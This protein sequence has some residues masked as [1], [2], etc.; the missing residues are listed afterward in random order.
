M[1]AYMGDS[2][3]SIDLTGAVSPIALFLCCVSALTRLLLQVLRQGSFVKKMHD[4]RWMEPSYF[5]S[6][7]DEVVL[8]HSVARYHAFVSPCIAS[9]FS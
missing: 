5:D 8:Q 2:I 9:A 1:S 3:F 7:D 4:L 6:E